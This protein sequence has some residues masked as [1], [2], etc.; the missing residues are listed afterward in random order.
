[1]T[2]RL[3]LGSRGFRGNVAKCIALAYIVDKLD[4][5]FEGDPSVGGSVGLVQVLDFS[6]LYLGNSAR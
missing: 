2:K 4:T 6:V 3:N 5:K 1:M